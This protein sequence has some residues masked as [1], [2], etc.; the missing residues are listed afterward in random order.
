MFHTSGLNKDRSWS[1]LQHPR[2]YSPNSY[3]HNKSHNTSVHSEHLWHT[4]EELEL[5]PA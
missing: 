4:L 2:S 5:L 1:N 3:N